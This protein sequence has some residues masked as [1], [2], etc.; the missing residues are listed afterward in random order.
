MAW[1]C[2]KVKYICIYIYILVIMFIAYEKKKKVNQIT[3]KQSRVYL[4]R[5]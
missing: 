2:E 3:H 5:K 4:T 1:T